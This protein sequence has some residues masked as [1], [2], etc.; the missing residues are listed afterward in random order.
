MTFFVILKNITIKAYV[1]FLIQRKQ[2]IHIKT[3]VKFHRQFSF[4]IK[5]FFLTIFNL[6]TSSFSSFKNLRFEFCLNRFIQILCKNSRIRRHSNFANFFSYDH[7]HQQYQNYFRFFVFWL[8][9]SLSSFEQH[10][11]RRFV[12]KRV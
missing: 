2:N 6:L 5:F 9:V 11:V 1:I 3:F 12:S 7:R 10:F 8:F 4:E